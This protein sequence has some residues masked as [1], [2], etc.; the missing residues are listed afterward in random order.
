M[1][2]KFEDLWREENKGME[3]RRQSSGCSVEEKSF[4]D[5]SWRKL[6]EE[7][8]LMEGSQRNY[9]RRRCLRKPS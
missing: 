6:L 5:N 8:V 4:K 7:D 2:Q 1:E 9:Q 3:L